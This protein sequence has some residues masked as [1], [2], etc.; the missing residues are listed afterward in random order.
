[1]HSVRQRSPMSREERVSSNP[2]PSSVPSRSVPCSQCLC[3]G[4]QKPQFFFHVPSL[5]STHMYSLVFK[6]PVSGISDL[7]GLRRKINRFRDVRLPHPSFLGLRPTSPTSLLPH[8]PTVKC[9]RLDQIE[10]PLLYLS[11]LERGRCM[12]SRQVH[13][14][15]AGQPLGL[16]SLYLEIQ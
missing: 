10:P 11:H 3:Q 14:R 6:W 16:N 7:P 8:P 13:E 15:L 9:N 4:F 2:H 1:M 5:L 12:R